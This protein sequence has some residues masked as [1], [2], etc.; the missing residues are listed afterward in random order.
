MWRHPR[1]ASLHCASLLTAAF[2]PPERL[3]VRFTYLTPRSS[4]PSLDRSSTT[5]RV[6]PRIRAV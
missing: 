5:Q 4:I 6:H 3:T 2:L 1:V